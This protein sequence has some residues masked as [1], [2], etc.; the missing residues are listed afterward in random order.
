[1]Y[2]LILSLFFCCFDPFWT[3]LE[4]QLNNFSP[5]NHGMY[6]KKYPLL[7]TASTYSSVI[8]NYIGKGGKGKTEEQV[9]C[10]SA[11]QSE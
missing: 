7:S 1:M 3:M 10:Q 4:G 6:L 8:P 11:W 2:Y 9:V 5:N